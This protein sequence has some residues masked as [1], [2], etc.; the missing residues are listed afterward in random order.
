M[1]QGLPIMLRIESSVLTM[2]CKA[3]C[4]LLPSPGAGK[5]G[6]LTSMGSHRVRHD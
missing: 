4:F 2:A 6:G 1:L 5:P 3:L